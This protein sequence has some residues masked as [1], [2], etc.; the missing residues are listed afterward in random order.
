MTDGYQRLYEKVLRDETFR[1]FLDA[2]PKAALES[3]DIKPTPEILEGVE[4][5]LK[6]IRELQ[7][8]FGVDET[9][10]KVCVT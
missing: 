5:T 7:D 2:D 10:K 1:E 8:D 6:A 4:N 9:I 3:I